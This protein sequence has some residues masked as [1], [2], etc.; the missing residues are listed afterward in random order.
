MCHGL[1]VYVGMYIHTYIYTHNGIE[2][3][4]TY[5]YVYVYTHQVITSSIFANEMCEKYGFVCRI[6]T[7]F[8]LLGT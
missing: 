7:N 5:T 3:I 2:Q 6:K 4:Y 1:Y 8:S